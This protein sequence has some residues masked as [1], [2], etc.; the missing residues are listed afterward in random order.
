MQRVVINL[1]KPLFWRNK[2]T[3]AENER[4]AKARREQYRRQNDTKN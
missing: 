3:K 2:L 4:R 1:N